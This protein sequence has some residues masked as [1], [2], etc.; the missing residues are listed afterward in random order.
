MNVEPT[1]LFT[2]SENRGR[3]STPLAREASPAYS[4]RDVSDKPMKI[5]VSSRNCG[6]NAALWS[7]NCGNSAEKNI[8]ALGLVA[9]VRKA[10]LNSFRRD[11]L[12]TF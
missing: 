5:D 1:A 11:G 3:F 10:D 6:S 7:M 8:V 2:H 4:V 12:L 9:A